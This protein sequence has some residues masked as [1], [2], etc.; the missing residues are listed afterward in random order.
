ML[1]TYSLLIAVIIDLIVGDPRR[2]HPL[3]GFGNIAN[4]LENKLNYFQTSPQFFFTTQRTV[5]MDIIDFTCCIFIV[6][7]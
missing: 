3:V 5:Y 2:W 4:W 1:L 6:L 7:D